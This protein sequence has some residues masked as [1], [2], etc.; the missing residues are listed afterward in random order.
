[1]QTPN[2]G[3]GSGIVKGTFD[4]ILH[5]MNRVGGAASVIGDIEALAKFTAIAGFNSNVADALAIEHNQNGMIGSYLG[6]NLVK[7]NNP[8][9][10]NSLTETALRK[11]L[12]YVI[13][14]G[15]S[16]L[17]PVKVVFEGQTQTTDA[18]VNINS[19]EVEFR[20][21]K[22]VGVGVVGVRKLLGIYEDQ[23]L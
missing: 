15:D 5:A 9:V 21:D 12:V 7:L 14:S 16:S 19:K 8:F 13:P 23:S 1:M 17:R 2:Y 10:P 18:P 4:P 20:F 6:G 11:D 3:A 22:Y